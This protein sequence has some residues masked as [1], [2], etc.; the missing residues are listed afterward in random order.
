[1]AGVRQG[2]EMI[3]FIPCF[4]LTISHFTDFGWIMR[5]RQGEGESWSADIHHES[6]RITFDGGLISSSS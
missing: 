3:V 1:M 4:K 5:L 6:V 2:S